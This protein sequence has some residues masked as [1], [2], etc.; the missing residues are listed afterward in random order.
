MNVVAIIT[1]LSLVLDGLFSSFLP[2]LVNDLSI[3]TTMFTVVIVFLLYPLFIG[4]NRKYYIYSFLLG[5]IYDLCYTN[6]FLYD[7][8]VFLLLAFVTVWIY[9]NFEVTKI[10]AVVCLVLIIALYEF[11]FGLMLF[12]F[13]LIPVTLEKIL[14]KFLHSLASNI[15][16]GEIIFIIIGLLPKKYHSKKINSFGKKI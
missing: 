10:H 11:L 7:A 9:K 5:V 13:N 12:A 15:L 3:F 1:I 2:Y 4:D 16:Y 8:L 14:Y 6:L